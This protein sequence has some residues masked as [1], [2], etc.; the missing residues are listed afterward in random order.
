MKLKE[1]NNSSKKTKELIKNA[2][3]ELIEE[4]MSIENI[5][6]TELVK[7]VNLTRGAFYSHYDNI[8]EVASEIQDEIL[9]TI[10]DDNKLLN[11]KNDVYNYIDTIFNHL[12]EHEDS[13][14][15]LL[16]S[17][18][19]MLFMHKLNKRIGNTLMQTFGNKVNHLD[20]LFFTDGTIN[21]IIQYFKR[22]IKEDLNDIR[23]YIKK[24]ISILFF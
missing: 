7:K 17:N 18:E 21:L 3:A 12:K 10:F 5:T 4:K 15:K 23:D 8:Y 11:T 9:E 22:E 24:M 1:L 14:H 20:I 6:V 19:P 2:F 16:T 13:Y